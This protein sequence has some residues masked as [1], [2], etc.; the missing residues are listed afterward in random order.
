MSDLVTRALTAGLRG[1][2]RVPEPAVRAL[3]A[4]GAE[5]APRVRPAA[6]DQLRVNLARV[7]P[8]L[9]DAALEALTREN[10]RRYLRYYAEMLTLGSLSGAQLAAR[11]RPRGTEHVL[12]PLAQGR[13]VVMAL[14]HLGNWDLAGAWA[15]PN[16]GPVVTVAEHLEPEEVFQG[17]LRVRTDL[18]MTI[19]PLEKDGSTFRTLVRHARAPEPS[20][21]PLLADRDLSRQGVPV[22]LFGE[23]ALVAPG[24]VALARAAKLPLVVVALAH[25]RLT[26][27]RRR[28]AGAAWGI[29]LAVSAPV[30]TSG[31]IQEATQRWVDVL[32]EAIRA[33]PADWHMLQPVWHADL[34]AARLARRAP[35]P[36]TGGAAGDAAGGAGR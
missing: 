34:D 14:G 10:V 11:V 36:G 6:F 32:A 23:P 30:D 27:Q 2:G 5:L 8:E 9:D 22:R 15:G 17:F 19:V 3:A 13:S 24:P 33:R 16:L 7:R 20:V 18:G 1:A 26:G 4:A 35:V 12:R 21:I 25:E 31:T 29:E 28:A